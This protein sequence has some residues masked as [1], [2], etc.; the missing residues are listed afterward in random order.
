M[1][2]FSVLDPVATATLKSVF[3]E[4]FSSRSGRVGML[5][6]I[7]EVKIQLDDGS[8]DARLK[9]PLAQLTQE[10]VERDRTGRA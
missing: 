3:A 7:A 4:D 2:A 9:E 10:I 1:L 6:A 5:A 8:Y